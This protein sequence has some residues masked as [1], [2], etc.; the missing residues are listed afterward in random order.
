[1]DILLYVLLS[2]NDLGQILWEGQDDIDLKA[3]KESLMNLAVLTH[4][5]YQIPFFPVCI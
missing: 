2:N 5:S 1:M 3:L 4:P